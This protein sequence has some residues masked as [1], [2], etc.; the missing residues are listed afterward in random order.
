MASVLLYMFVNCYKIVNSV[1][2]KV[3]NLVI[4]HVDFYFYFVLVAT[5]FEVMGGLGVEYFSRDTSAG[6]NICIFHLV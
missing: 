3:Y 6:V 2:T 5:A 1:V 4:L